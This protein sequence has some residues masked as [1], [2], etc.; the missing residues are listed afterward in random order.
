MQVLL[1]A[2]RVYCSILCVISYIITVRKYFIIESKA[3]CENAT[4][5]Y[6]L[7][8]FVYRGNL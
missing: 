5:I 3:S 2:L 8:Y 4:L 1:A 7:D 6:F